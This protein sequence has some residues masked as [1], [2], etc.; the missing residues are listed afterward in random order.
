LALIWNDRDTASDAFVRAYDALLAAR[1]PRYLELQGKSDT[2]AAFDA[3][4]GRGRWE[5]R[6]LPNAQR[7]DRGGLVARVMS[8]SYAPREGEPGH[9]ALASDLAA[10]FDAHAVDGHVTIPYATVVIAG[11]R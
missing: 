3:L 2:P 8:S 5:R 6:A 9:D 4:F 10:L 7:L 1:C 11:P